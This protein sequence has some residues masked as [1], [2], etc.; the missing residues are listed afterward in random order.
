MKTFLP[1]FT[2]QLLALFSFALIV[3]S[4]FATDLIV[5]G[6]TSPSDA[7]GTY[8]PNGT[9][10]GKDSWKHETLNYYIYYDVYSGD[11]NNYWNIDVDTDD[12][13]TALFYTEPNPPSDSPVNATSWSPDAGTGSPFV[14]ISSAFP[15]IN[16]KGN[17]INIVNTSTAI[18]FNNHTKFGSADISGGTI[19]RTFTIEN[20]GSVDL[21]ITSATISGTNAADFSVTTAPSSTVASLGNT[22]FSVTFDPSAEGYRYATISIA[23][24]DTDENPYTFDI[25]GRGFV[26]GDLVV[27]GITTPADANGNYIH[28]GVINNFEYWKHET[29]SYYLFND[30][31]SGAQYWNF[32]IDTDDT[33]NDFLFYIVSEQG[34]PA[35]LSSWDKNTNITVEGDPVITEAISAPNINV[36]ANGLS[37]ADDDV[38][39]T[40]TDHTNFNSVEVSSGN[41]T[42]TFTIENTGGA[43]LDI[44]SVNIT[45]T[46]AGDFSLTSPP[47]ATVA[48]FGSTSFEITFDPSAAGIREAEI[49]ISNNDADEN[50]YNFK[51]SGHGMVPT[52][53]LVS[54]I[55][56]PADAN[57]TYTY[58]GIMFEYPYWMNTSGYYIYNDIWTDDKRY[59]EID[60]DTDDATALFFSSVFND[61]DPS[62]LNVSSWGL[63]TGTGIPNLTS[64]P[65][66]STDGPSIV[67]GNS[68][69][70]TL[71]FT[72]FLSLPAP[73]GGATVDYA[74]SDG[75]ATA[76]TDYTSVSGTLSFA[77]GET[78]KTVD[79]TVTGDNMLEADETFTLTLSNATGTDVVIT[80]ATG[81]GTI[82]NDDAAAVT[83]ADVSSNE[84]DGAITVTATLDNAVQG[85][86]QVNVNTTDGTATTADNDY[87]AVSGHTL[88]FAGTAGEM[89]T[90][91]VTPNTDTK[92]EANETATVSMSNLA[93]TTLGVVIT[94]NATVTFNN[95][96]AAAVTI[97]NASGNEDDGA[98]TL[99]ATLD[100]AVQGG[101]QVD[102]STS[103]GTATTADNDYT[104]ISGQTL[105]FAGNSGET[106]TFTVTPTSDS[107]VES[108]ETITIS[109]S[110]LTTTT[111]A[112]DISDDA[113]ITINNDDLPASVT[114]VNS[115]TAN[116]TYKIGD[117][118]SVSITFS[119]TVTVTGTPQ[120][121]LETGTTDQNANYASGSGTTVLTFSYTVQSG[122]ETADLDYTTTSAL[123]LNAG[124]INDQFGTP[125]DLTL[126]SPGAAGS[127]GA[128]KAIV[129]D[130]VAPA[131][132]SIPDLTASTDLG[133]SSSDNITAATKPDFQGT[134][135]A[136]STVTLISS[137]DG[138][139]GTTTADGSGNWFFHSSTSVSYGTHSITATATD[140]VGNTG[141]ASAG[142]S[143]T[144]DANSGSPIDAKFVMSPQ[145]G[146]TVPHTVFFTDQSTLPDTWHWD[147]GNGNT[148]SAQ[149]PIHSYTNVGHF[150]ITLTITDTILGVTDTYQDSLNVSI[151]S[152]EFT[153]NSLFGC[154][155]LTVDFTDNSIVNGPDTI[156]AWSWDFGDGGTSTEQHP[157]Y[158]YETA[159]VYT[160]KLTITASNGCS[161]TK[162]QTNYIQ[163]NGP[164]ADFN[165][166]SVTVGCPPL[167]VIFTNETTSGAPIVSWNWDFGDGSTGNIQNP[168]H[169]FTAF[170]TFDISLTVTDLD[171]CSKTII[172]N[173][174]IN[175]LDTVSPTAI[176]QNTEIYLDDSGIGSLT[177]SDIDNGSSDNCSIDSLWL[178]KD[179]FSCSELGAHTIILY[180]S[181]ASGNIDFCE[182][183]VTVT[184]T[185]APVYIGKELLTY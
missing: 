101:F 180:A 87:T 134:A 140:T 106:Q 94:D 181:D 135:E 83:I 96:D 68:G 146:C 2:K 37:I 128:N 27:S 51:I 107:K 1:R 162:T 71:A 75:T 5:S 113:S 93:A 14:G 70:T 64:R 165:T 76:G 13:N 39:P 159:G 117:I 20:Q 133:V 34:T 9:L 167:E 164:D 25:R 19:V 173:N 61:N 116:G 99:T 59:W 62:P 78:S 12:E 119:R 109:Q 92:L 118:I 31:Y 103:D 115:S 136:N 16:V 57:G 108:D 125:A 81:T 77:A 11:G 175:T 50:P 154:G 40:Y 169:T 55:L 142:L 150:I 33:D 104:A 10:N 7:N 52:N 43:Q 82:T 18:S 42:R 185:T 90:F 58:Q 124:T 98:I 160:V 151:P 45:G 4:G 47:S 177:V 155:P 145:N 139:L 63:G 30:E 89:Q 44:S 3:H 85:G 112:V 105:T 138:T 24:D 143:V 67:E 111:L 130:G 72:V 141:S 157:S 171:G 121:L 54:D 123:M 32:D 41:R 15:E 176:C 60:N 120:L 122:D 182:A 97:A 95:D 73:A 166:N 102:V 127:L 147:F 172:M 131:A 38:T 6:I 168:T 110:N 53:I 153:G 28:Q 132:P 29:N 170:D 69:S 35:G 114:N 178:S 174:L 21:N 74:T 163:V 66:F 179:E 8:V 36:K 129:I 149:N 126:I 183:I 79:I 65:G 88:T 56:T 91:T 17:G 161:S 84:D 26:P 144:I 48:A 148:S 46:N 137:L 22:T 100:N 80:D 152:A 184:D 86:F 156:T 158:S 23:N 49:S